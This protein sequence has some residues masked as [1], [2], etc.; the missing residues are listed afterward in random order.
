MKGF[1]TKVVPE[2]KPLPKKKPAHHMDELCGTPLCG[3]MY[4]N[5]MEGKVCG[6]FPCHCTTFVPTGQLYDWNQNGKPKQ[7]IVAE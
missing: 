1:Q 2:A 5:H 6:V 4:R 3:D 7:P